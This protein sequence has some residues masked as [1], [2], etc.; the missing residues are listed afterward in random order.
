[1][2]DNVENLVIEQLKALRNEIKDFR[3]NYERD[4]SDIK[5]RLTRVEEG[6]TGLR[7]ENIG[8]QEDIYRQQTTIDTI[9]ERINKIEKRLELATA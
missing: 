1:M 5:H 9:N 7:K 8:V 6:I 3:N 4:A 2:N